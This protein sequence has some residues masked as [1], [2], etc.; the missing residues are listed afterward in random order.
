M[1]KVHSII[2]LAALHVSQAQSSSWND[3]AN[4]LDYGAIANDATNDVSAFSAALASQKSVV[5][6]PKGIYTLSDLTSYLSLRSNLDIFCEDGAVLHVPSGTPRINSVTTQ[7]YSFN[8]IFG[9]SN[10]DPVVSN[11]N[12][13]GCSFVVEER[14]ITPVQIDKEGG[15]DITI[16][17]VSVDGI[18]TMNNNQAAYGIFINNAS[19]VLIENSNISH[20]VVDGIFG[21]L[22][23]HWVIKGNSITR[24]GVDAQYPTSTPGSAALGSDYWNSGGISAAAADNTIITSNTLSYTGGAGIILRGGENSCENN[25]ITNNKLTNIGKGAIG[26]GINTGGI[27]SSTG[28]VIAENTIQGFMQRFPD[29]A[30]NVNHRGSGG[31]ITDLVIENNIID[32]FAPGDSE[33]N[34]PNHLSDTGVGYSTIYVSPP[35]GSL[36]NDINIR[37]NIIR[38]ALGAAISIEHTSES[39]ISNNHIYKSARVHTGNH[40]F[41]LG[42]VSPYAIFFNYV[43]LSALKE[44]TI[45]DSHDGY[46]SGNAAVIFLRGHKNDAINNAVINADPAKSAYGLLNYAIKGSLYQSEYI[47]TDAAVNNISGNVFVGSEEV[48]NKACRSPLNGWAECN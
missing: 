44:N 39:D 24:A 33:L 15:S 4:V 7:G 19:N 8:P 25:S 17:G 36:G 1:K 42:A 32:M 16:S 3:V 23:S 21:R 9:V 14:W 48:A 2:I 38:N 30:I 12:I 11:I 34:Y 20:T 27:G 41:N 45:Q 43:Y 40:A 35:V 5:Y 37:G 26:I 29:S 18:G 28:N 22:A 46:L 31:N 47:D 6:V 10:T 13:T